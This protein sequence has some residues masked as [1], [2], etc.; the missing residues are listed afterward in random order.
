WE[1]IPDR[2]KMEAIPLQKAQDNGLEKHMQNFV[3]AIL[4]RDKSLVNAP[5]E[6]GSHVATISQ[7]GNIAYRTGKKI[8]WDNNQKKFTDEASNA[9][10][11][12]NYHNGYSI[13]KV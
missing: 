7:M 11:A 2:N 5:I 13:P 12:A 3:S 1:V 9:Y 10:L 4:K 6:A 8:Y